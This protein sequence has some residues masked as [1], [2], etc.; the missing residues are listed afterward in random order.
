[1]LIE[2]LFAIDTRINICKSNNFDEIK[3]QS[4][5]DHSFVITNFLDDTAFYIVMTFS[6][7]LVK[8]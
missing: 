1:M 7:V 3:Q 2:V 4:L 6:F 5:D 8:Y